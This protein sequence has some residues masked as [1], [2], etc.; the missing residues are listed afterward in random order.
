MAVAEG[1][2]DGKALT[3]P[4]MAKPRLPAAGELKPHPPVVV[5]PLA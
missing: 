4:P 5:I 2:R 3:A 1:V